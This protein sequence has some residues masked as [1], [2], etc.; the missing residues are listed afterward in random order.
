MLEILAI[1]QRTIV[2]MEPPISPQ[3]FALLLFAGMLILLETGR[4]VGVKRLPKESDGER[5]SLGTIRGRDFCTR[6]GW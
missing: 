1:W 2:P 3:L 6:L 5:G 4:R